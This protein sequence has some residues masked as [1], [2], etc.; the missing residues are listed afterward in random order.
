MI[1]E[2]NVYEVA[3]GKVPALNELFNRVA[4]GHFNS[5]SFQPAIARGIGFSQNVGHSLHSSPARGSRG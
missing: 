1:S 3:P 4:M 2:L 5:L